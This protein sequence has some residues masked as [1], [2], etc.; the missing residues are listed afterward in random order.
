MTGFFRRKKDQR[1]TP[2]KGEEDPYLDMIAKKVNDADGDFFGEVV[3]ADE[4]AVIIKHQGKFYSFPAEA[5]QNKFGDLMLSGNV[6]LQAA[7]KQGEIWKDP[8]KV[9]IAENKFYDFSEKRRLEEEK[10]QQIMDEMERARELA[11]Q[12]HL[13][14][15]EEEPSPDDVVDVAGEGNGDAE[16]TIE[17]NTVNSKGLANEI[18]KDDE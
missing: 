14:P 2:A 12:T 9:V 10:E 4:E 5:I 3:S 6:D 16:E 1:E 13:G 17:D 15:I 7:Q 18:S 8:G 11:L